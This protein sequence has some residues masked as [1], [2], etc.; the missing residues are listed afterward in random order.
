M[1]EPK[2]P[3]KFS[4]GNSAHFFQRFYRSRKI[5]FGVALL[6]FAIWSMLYPQR[7]L[8][9]WMTP[10]QQGRL[11]FE[12]GNYDKAAKQFQNPLWKGMSLYASEEFD[13]AALLFSQYQDENGLLAQ[14]NALAHARNYVQAV[15]VYKQLMEKYPENSA[16]KTNIAIVQARI[17]ENQLMSESQRAEAGELS[18]EDESGPRSSEG[19]ERKQFDLSPTQQLSSEQ[20][21]QDTALTEMWMRQ[22]Q[23]DPTQFLRVKFYMQLEQQ[24]KDGQRTVDEQPV[25]EDEPADRDG[26]QQ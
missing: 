16:A 5:L 14:G 3:Q 8:T 7:F 11:L 23:K 13:T 1:V 21:L 10:D 6:S 19:D 18:M 24:E 25:E 12:M 4:A 20:L 26:A 17:D 9:L 15:Q 22:V 2:P